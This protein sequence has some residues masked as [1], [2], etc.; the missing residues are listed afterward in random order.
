M[1]WNV[2]ITD[3]D[4][5][6]T[7]LERAEL[8]TIGA[9][10]TRVQCLSED[11]VIHKCQRADALM[12]Q[13]APITRRVID[14]LPNLKAISRYGIGYD[15]ID[16]KAAAERGIPVCNVPDYCT[17]EVATHAFTLLL[18][19][20]R[21]LIPLAASTAAGSWSVLDVARP[22][23]RLGGQ[24]LGLVGGGRIGRQL[25]AMAGSCGLQVIIHDPYAEHAGTKASGSYVS[26]EAL[27]SRS[28]FISIHC[29]LNDETAGMFNHDAFQKMKPNAVLINTSR[30]GVVDT[31]ALIAALR[32]GTIGGA[33][34]DVLADE[35]PQPGT[36]P[37]NTPNLIVTP[38]AAW[39]SE[40][41][42]DAL[43]QGTA[44]AIVD[45]YCSKLPA[46]VVNGIKRIQVALEGQCSLLDL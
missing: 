4:M 25:A 11:D 18:A 38:H 29:P 10:L 43:Q 5:E 31:E 15:M 7:E 28:D 42:L 26:W 46:S 35:P 33:A 36:L 23:H 1:T 2:F 39:Y 45:L 9:H 24:V 17:E 22:V 13:W 3:L 32:N 19:S 16:V 41:A 20:A 12:V 27:L 6:H 44:R 21:K 30:G 37:S 40:E 8:A 34:I 14:H